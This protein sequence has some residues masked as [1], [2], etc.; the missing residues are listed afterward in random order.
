MFYW[1]IV[2]D[3]VLCDKLFN[4]IED[5]KKSEHKFKPHVTVR[6][7][8]TNFSGTIDRYVLIE[9]YDK[10]VNLLKVWNLE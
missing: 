8:E 4:T 6:N 7:G 1:G 2:K 3:F 10:T 9:K 5:I